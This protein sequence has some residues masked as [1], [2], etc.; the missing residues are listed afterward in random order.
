MIQSLFSGQALNHHLEPDYYKA[1]G[2]ACGF[3]ALPGQELQSVQTLLRDGVPDAIVDLDLQQQ[4]ETVQVAEAAASAAASREEGDEKQ[5]DAEL[6]NAF[7]RILK[8]EQNEG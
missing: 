8:T 6:Y 5:L 3:L 2:M 7:A 1:L 4:E